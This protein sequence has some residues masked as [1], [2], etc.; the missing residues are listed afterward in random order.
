MPI[1]PSTQ[2][3]NGWIASVQASGRRHRVGRTPVAAAIQAGKRRGQPFALEPII[4]AT[5]LDT[6][7]GE[8]CYL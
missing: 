3:I 7:T 4:I 6:E 5:P 8:S 1:A 2:S